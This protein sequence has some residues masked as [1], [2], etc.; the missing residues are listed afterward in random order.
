MSDEGKVF[1]FRRPAVFT[2]E[3]RDNLAARLSAKPDAQDAVLTLEDELC[4]CIVEGARS[5]GLAIGNKLAD[6]V[7]G[8]KAGN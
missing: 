5:V 7:F 6:L 4:R 3:Q 2:Q 8:K 1:Q